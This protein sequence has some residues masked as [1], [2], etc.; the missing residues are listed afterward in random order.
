MEFDRAFEV[1]ISHEGVFTN[2]PKDR[3]NWTSGVIG[4]GSLNGTKFGISAMTYPN[5]DIKNLTLEV[6]KKIYYKDFWLAAKCDILPDDLKLD[7][8]D[9]AVNS[10]IKASIKVLQ[11][12]LGVTQDGVLGA[13]SIEALKAADV[14]KLDKR[15]SG[16]RLLFI[17]Q[18]KTFPTFGRGWIVRV[19]NNLIID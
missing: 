6:A 13:K 1:L 19:A 2:N 11:Q 16:Y 14:A 12:A 5:I 7:V 18:T 10:G 17:A 15:M 8:F 3:G 9:M 4:K